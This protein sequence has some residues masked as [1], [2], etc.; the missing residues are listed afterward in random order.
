MML[1]VGLYIAFIM[2]RYIPSIPSFL[3]GFIMKAGSIVLNNFSIY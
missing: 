2:L 1:A 3:R